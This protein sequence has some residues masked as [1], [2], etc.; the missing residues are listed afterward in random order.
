MPVVFLA[1]IDA[2]PRIRVSARPW[3]RSYARHLPAAALAAAL[4][5][6]TTLPL[7]GLTE[8][9]A[10]RTPPNVTADEKLLDRIPDGSTVES[11][12][13]P[14]SR[15]AHR[16]RVFWIGDTG[17]LAPEFV[18]VQ[19]RDDRTPRQVL[20]ETAARHPRSTYVVL[21]DTADLLVFRRTSSR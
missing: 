15:L 6:T 3:L 7:S 1:L 14:L 11:D 21:G 19:L 10:Y 18:A 4:A 20:A 5:L 2:L 16:T 8:A 12:I 13:R 9:A 17:G